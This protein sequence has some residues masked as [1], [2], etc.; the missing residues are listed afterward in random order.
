[1]G[2]SLVLSYSSKSVV[3]RLSNVIGYDMGKTNFIGSLIY[4]A[5]SN[6]RVTFRT[7]RS[8]EKDYIWIDDVVASLL[9]LGKNTL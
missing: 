7:S 8:S 4:E 6:N 9:L 5:R 1:M 2:E 3:A